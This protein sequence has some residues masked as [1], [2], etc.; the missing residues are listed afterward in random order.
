MPNPM[1]SE[2]EIF[3]IAR[4]ITDPETRSAYL[5]QACGGDA[6]LFERIVELL[7]V[8]EDDADSFLENPPPGIAPTVE[9][10]PVREKPGDR[11]GDFKLL[12]KIG[13]GGFGVVY[14]AEQT[15]PVKRRVAL[16]IIKP[17]MDTREVIARFEAER[18]SLAMM[19][20]P[21]IAKVIDGG[22]TQSGRP[23]FVMEL[24][25]GVPLIQFCDEQKL[26][27]EARLKLF[28]MVCKA[29]QHAHHKGVIHR[30]IKPANVLVT[31][32]D[33]D[34]VPKVID[35]GISKAINQQLTEKTLF[36]NF[37][38]M[39]GTPQYMS[40]EQ[41]ERSGLDVDTRCDVY[42]LGVLLYEL[43][44]GTTPLEA[45]RL[46][47]AGFM[48]MQRL[49]K[50]EEPPKPSTRVSGIGPQVTA[51]A[52]LRGVSPDSLRRTLRGDLDWIVMKALEKDRTRRYETA[53][54]FAEEIG[55][56]LNDEPVT[57][58][59]PTWAYRSR[60]F[61]NRHR[62]VI[63]IAAG[64]VVLSLICMTWIWQLYAGSQTLL[65]G[66]QNEL[67]K[68]AT[69]A[70]FS[71]KPSKFGPAISRCKQYKVDDGQCAILEALAQF[72]AGE[73]HEAATNAAKLME[74][75]ETAIAGASIL[76]SSSFYASSPEPMSEAIAKLENADP[77]SDLDK[78]LMSQA[79]LY[80]RPEDAWKYTEQLK[81]TGSDWQAL[82][83]V[84]A[85][86]T[87]L[88][89]TEIYDDPERTLQEVESA[90]EE[91]KY[92][93]M[94]ELDN[95]YIVTEYFQALLHAL[96]LSRR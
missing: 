84:N 31:L 44:T 1:P 92:L 12:Q 3:H 59:P 51:A 91:L 5:N 47:E 52:K 21:N 86:A 41:A 17:G 63:G 60:K 27:T 85:M 40:P 68:Q 32:H 18:Q 45:N 75:D 8:T 16:K 46:R 39:V 80:L 26:S 29:I 82:R 11:I 55:R 50:E 33:G 70:A 15:K 67:V 77:Q 10:Q 43:L 57:A 81:K 49:I 38:Q 87:I 66:L 13:E 96:D 95:Q 64:Y 30:D 25:H 61:V 56:Y 62:T 28:V 6:S 76:F 79:I 36:T 89:A 83:T 2:D 4:G 78:L 72:H 7:R 65:V 58:V 14:M 22:E 90:V 74:D 35:F 53:N 54:G 20:H 93:A 69:V 37:G 73:L 19:N 88:R 34:P 24:V 94:N 9:R 42:S 48:E 71:G 23:Y